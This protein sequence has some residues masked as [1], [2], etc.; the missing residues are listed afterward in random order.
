[1]ERSDNERAAGID[2]FPEGASSVGGGGGRRNVRPPP[3]IGKVV[4]EIWCYLPE[5]YEYTFGEESEIQ[6]VFSKKCKKSQFSIEILIKKS[7]DFLET[8]QNFLHF[9][10]NPAEFCTQVS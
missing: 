3:E 5:V 2:L 7:Q 9:W 8:F 6:K 4:V 1:M 10:S